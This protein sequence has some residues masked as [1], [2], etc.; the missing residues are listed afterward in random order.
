MEA[1]M[2]SLTNIKP[3]SSAVV[4]WSAVSFLTASSGI[5]WAGG[6]QTVA[7]TEGTNIAATLSPDHGTIIFDLQGVL[8]ALPV[9]G[10]TAKRLTEDFLEPARPDWSPTG[11]KVVFEAYA[12]GTF[13]IWMM[14]P[15]GSEGTQLTD[16]HFDD[17]VPCFSPDGR[18]N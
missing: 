1:P 8:W 6:T 5:V 11:D 2:T 12:G 17:R 3:R 16:G 14:I 10:G 13:H 15:V 9:E 4:F 18:S 7:V